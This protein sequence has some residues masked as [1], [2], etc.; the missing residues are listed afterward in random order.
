MQLV[1]GVEEES[2]VFLQ[3][4][5]GGGGFFGGGGGGG[6][7]GEGFE[8]VGSSGLGGVDGQ[9]GGVGCY[10]TGVG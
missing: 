7:G 4:C 8:E 9:I 6:G 10:G 5:R 3:G 2:Q 1:E